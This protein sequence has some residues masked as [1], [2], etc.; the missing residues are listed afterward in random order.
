MTYLQDF[1]KH[2]KNNDYT[3]FLKLWEEYCYSDIPDVE[4]L[5]QILNETK[6]SELAK[7]FGQHVQRAL[8]LWEKIEDEQDQYDVLKLIIDIQNKND[9]D[10]AEITY[11]T[12]EKK[13]ANDK[14][15]NEKIR[16][17]GLR[18][19]ENFQGAIS[20]Y[21]LLS[22]VNKGKFVFHTSG[23]GTGEII[24]FSLIR[25]EMTLEFEYVIGHKNLSFD[26]ALK[27]LVP[28][29]DEHFL[30]CRFGN[31]DLL[32]KKAKE[33][34]IEVIKLLLK[35]LGPKNAAEIKDNLCELVIPASDWNR[36][37]QT[38]PI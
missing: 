25:E 5:K 37:W 14:L 13:Y 23:W 8:L 31:P 11:K 16:L 29:P 30:S 17:V 20:K 32:E 7:S 10:L 2:I 3:N 21:E 4:E 22:H 28:L 24:D 19:G 34:P 9:E 36:W 33:N 18:T 1:Q 6:N 12:L 27:T 38:V 15:F 26:N 35:D